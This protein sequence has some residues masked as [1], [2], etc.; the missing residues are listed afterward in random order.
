[1]SNQIIVHGKPIDDATR[2]VH[3]HSP[4]DVIAIK[5]KCC[6]KYY[7][8]YQCHEE[9]AGHKAQ[10]WKIDEWDTPAVLC[11]LCK[12]ELSI[13]QYMHSRNHCPHCRAAF[14]PNCSKHYDLYFDG[15][16]L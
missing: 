11:G 14:N 16:G 5:F 15:A 6:G 7:P 3:Y 13:E 9:E 8:C 4:L 2:C 12:T 1:M 10:T